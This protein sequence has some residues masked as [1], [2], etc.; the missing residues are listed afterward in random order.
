WVLHSAP[1]RFSKKIYGETIEDDTHW[2]I[3]ILPRITKIAGF[4]IGSGLYIN[5]FPPE[6]IAEALRNVPTI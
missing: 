1:V 6:E 3:H 4:E 5:P 2:H